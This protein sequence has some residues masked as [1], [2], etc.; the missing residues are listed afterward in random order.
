MTKQVAE[1]FE[2]WG[3][4]MWADPFIDQRSIV[5]NKAAHS[6]L[7]HLKIQTEL[8]MRGGKG[9]V[10]DNRVRAEVIAMLERE[11]GGSNE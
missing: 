5:T 11:L 8:T 7:E 1:I 4:F 3:H 10:G 2:E 6:L 9:H